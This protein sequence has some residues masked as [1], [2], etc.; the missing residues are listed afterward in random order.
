MALQRLPSTNAAASVVVLQ[1]ASTT[2]GQAAAIP[3]APTPWASLQRA[4]TTSTPASVPMALSRACTFTL[5]SASAPGVPAAAAQQAH[6]SMLQRTGTVTLAEPPGSSPQLNT[7]LQRT[8]TVTLVEAPAAPGT[9]V[10]VP[11]Q[12]VSIPGVA[13]PAGPAM[14]GGKSIVSTQASK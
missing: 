2:S 6:V 14:P 5:P 13:V 9:T 12:T 4:S 8:G 1:R 3:Q 10:A 7:S 11:R